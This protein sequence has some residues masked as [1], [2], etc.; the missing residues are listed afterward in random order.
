MSMFSKS[1]DQSIATMMAPPAEGASASLSSEQMAAIAY[2]RGDKE[3]ALEYYRDAAFQ[4][5][6]DT[7][8]QKAL[9]DFC[10]VGLDRPDEAYS[11]YRTVLALA[12]KDPDVLQILGNL[13]VTS[14]K[15]GEARQYFTALAELQPDNAGAKKALAALPPEGGMSVTPD[16]FRSMIRDA[17]RSMSTSSSTDVEE[18]LD[19][20]MQFKSRKN[21]APL[22]K[23]AT[24]TYEDICTQATEG[25]AK[26]TI[27]AL[28]RF[29][30]SAAGH[31][32]AH[33]D[34]G[35]L[36]Y[37]TGR[38]AEAL[39]QYQKAVALEPREITFRKNLADYTYIE[40]HDAESALRHYVD[41]LTTSPRDA[42]TLLAL[43]Q[44]CIDL[45]KDGDALVFLDM[46]LS[47]EPW[48]QQAREMRAALQTRA[49]L[50]VGG[51]QQTS[52]M[53]QALAAHAAGRTDEAIRLLEAHVRANP[54][55]AEARNDLGVLYYQAG[56]P[57]EAGPQ[58]EE[59]SRLDPANEVYAKNMADYY[60]IEMG[61][62]EDALKIYVGLLTKK[63][64]DV[65]TLLGIGKICEILNRVQD[66]KDFYRK[67]LEA[68]PWNTAAR[69]QLGR[70]SS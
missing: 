32:A 44:V 31:A 25:N 5:P 17:Q 4:A 41:I 15:F 47:S 45:Q 69:E 54:L 22:H 30:A 65:D 57:A 34:L 1:G 24:L 68:E 52:M 46:L 59:A 28:E 13:C 49:T 7:G 11:A 40:L 19:R 18:A 2:R 38:T 56:R 21:A 61:R 51:T 9:A 43:A 60:V 53:E 37:R 58:Y 67:A 20:L 64:R 33:N 36:Y 35:V 55:D 12:P 62:T 50:P 16:A 39:T 48:N 14:Q 10:L 66:A 23:E 27:A 6:K 3:K 8:V 42:E 70:L 29:V 63:P 26:E